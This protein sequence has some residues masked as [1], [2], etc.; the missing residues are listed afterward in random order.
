M[1]EGVNNI[2]PET[3]MKLQNK[4][5]FNTVR[6]LITNEALNEEEIALLATHSMQELATVAVHL[7]SEELMRLQDPMIILGTIASFYMNTLKQA[8]IPQE[9]SNYQQNMLIIQS[10]Q[11]EKQKGISR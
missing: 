2:T 7:T 1:P 10:I 11:K 6:K 3:M 5:L 8:T 4:A 9:L